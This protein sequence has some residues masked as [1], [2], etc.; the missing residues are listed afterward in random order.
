M[1]FIFYDLETTGLAPQWDVPLQAALIHTDA[2]LNIQAELSFRAR[3]PAHIVPSPGALLVTGVTPA[4]LEQAPLSVGEILGLIARAFTGWAPATIVT[5][6][7]LRFDEEVLRHAFFTHLLPPYAT[8]GPGLK[9]ADLLVMLRSVRLLEPGAVTIPIGTNGKP[10]MKLG[11]VCCAN[12]ITLHEDDAHDALADTRATLAL[13]RHLRK[14]APSTIALMLENAQKSGPAALLAGEELILLGGMTAMAP[15]IGVAPS[16]RNA[17]AWA[18]A[19]LSVDPASYLD[20]PV[21]EIAALLTAKG[22]RTIRTVRTNAQPILTGWEHGVH[23]LPADRLD[24]AVYRRRARQVRDHEGFR[25]NLML[26]LADQYADAE[27]SHWPE[28][29]LYSGGFIA[30]EQIRLS[31][32]WHE[33][34]WVQ[35]PAFADK[36]FTD[37]R[38]RAFANRLTFL[39]AAEHLSPAAWAKGRDWLRHRLLTQD[40]VPWLTL[41]KA[42]HETDVLRAQAEPGDGERLRQLAEIERW[43][44]ER[45]QELAR[46]SA[47]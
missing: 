12:G 22:P 2:D 16:P 26:A 28:A 37:L 42:L 36:L 41:P 17:A 9:R 4:M 35:R 13:F 25:K 43:L 30:D 23:A 10:S 33:I 19:D 20:S 24:D 7:G 44:V 46:A 11:D 40:D 18:V 39:N 14:V 27:P 31:R 45:Q 5:Y 6:N 15:V 38:M 1:S 8:Q 29:T 47:A 32:R 3:L 34:D 21:E